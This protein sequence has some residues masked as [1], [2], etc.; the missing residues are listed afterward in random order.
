MCLAIPMRILKVEGNV[1]F[2]EVGG[3]RRRIYLDLIE[4][5]QEGDYVIVHTGY[6]IH[7]IDESEARENLELI[8]QYLSPADDS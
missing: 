8:H 3:V 5:A 1:G 2:V 4:E 7:K 6:A